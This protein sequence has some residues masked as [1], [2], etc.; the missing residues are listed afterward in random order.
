MS[1]LY[2]RAHKKSSIKGTSRQE[3]MRYRET[4][5]AVGGSSLNAV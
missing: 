1:V 2:G 5:H 3:G 4:M